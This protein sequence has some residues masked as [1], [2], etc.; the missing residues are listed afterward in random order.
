M[1]PSDM[2]GWKAYLVSDDIAWMH[3]VNGSLYAINPEY[4]FF[5]VAPGTNERTNPNAWTP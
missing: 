4:G 2:E 1:P 5:G 3:S